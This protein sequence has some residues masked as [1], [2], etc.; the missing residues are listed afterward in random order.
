M[1]SDESVWHPG[2]FQDQTDASEII[3]R[4]L[5]LIATRWRMTAGDVNLAG[6]GWRR[7]G[8]VE[9]GCEY[10]RAGVRVSA[11]MDNYWSML[12][13]RLWIIYSTKS[14]VSTEPIRIDFSLIIICHCDNY[15]WVERESRTVPRWLTCTQQLLIDLQELIVLNNYTLSIIRQF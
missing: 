10:E 3:T 8:K 6:E 2:L 11:V 4:L 14:A 9:D 12:N 1:H 13:T 15:L 5:V 7:V